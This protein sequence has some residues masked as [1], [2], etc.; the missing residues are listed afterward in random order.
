MSYFVYTNF[1]NTFLNSQY[2]NDL[3]YAD[4][5]PAFKKNYINLTKAITDL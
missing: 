1:K 2:P 5:T 4:V 3:R